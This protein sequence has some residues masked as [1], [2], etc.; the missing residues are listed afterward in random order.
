MAVTNL[1]PQ[2]RG[3][4]PKKGERV[5]LPARYQTRWDEPF[6]TEIEQVLRPGISILDVGSGR[7]PSIPAGDRP[8][9]VHYVGLDLSAEELEAAAPGEYDE[10]VVADV[11]TLKDELVG[12]FDVIVSWQ[13]LEHV[14]DLGAAFVCMRAYLKPGGTHISLFSGKGSVFA[15]INRVIPFHI[16]AP[17]VKKVMGRSDNSDPVFPAFYDRCN[18]TAL[19]KMTADWSNVEIKPY[20]VGARYFGF[21]KIAQ[22]AYL[23]YENFLVRR[24]HVNLA[25]HYLLVAT[26]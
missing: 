24:N 1:T 25:T 15:A 18:D 20:W 22:Q 7:N 3:E 19:R 16:G 12:R 14:E 6:R 5:S 26:R 17:I 9:D 10:H 11:G 13:V 8:A 4:S 21:A 2:T 23:A